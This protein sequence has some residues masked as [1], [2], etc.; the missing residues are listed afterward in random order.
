MKI[1]K[2]VF[3]LAFGF[4]FCS[5]TSWAGEYP[6]KLVCNLVSCKEF[7]GSCGDLEKNVE[8]NVLEARKNP[9]GGGSFSETDSSMRLNF[10]DGGDYVTYYEFDKSELARLEKGES[11]SVTGSYLDAYYWADGMHKQVEAKFDCH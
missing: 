1:S 3:S 9:S 4:A 8:L 10:G 11:R 6:D 7:E 2:K 5:L